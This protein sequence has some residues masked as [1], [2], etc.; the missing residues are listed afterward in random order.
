LISSL[1]LK[2]PGLLS[3]IRRIIWLSF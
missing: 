1:L 3:F 2:N